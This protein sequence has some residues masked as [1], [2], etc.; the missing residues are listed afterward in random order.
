M[1]AT[2]STE[3]NKRIARRVPEDIATERNLDLIDEVFAADAVET[4]PFGEYRGLESIR[5]GFEEIL[6]AFPDL[7]ATV[8]EC[9]CE[10]DT[11]AMRVTLRGTHEGEFNGRA[12]TGKQFEV[13][14]AVFTRIEDGRI[15]ERWV[16]PDTLGLTRQLGLDAPLAE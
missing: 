15:V 13:D 7:S 4:D 1:A 6:S 3:T 5:E 9:I 8:E 11:V 2:S 16:Q 12:P 10:G 14:N